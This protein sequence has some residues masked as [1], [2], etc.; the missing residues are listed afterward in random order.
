[1]YAVH[2]RDRDRID[3][4][5]IFAAAAFLTGI[6]LIAA[7]ARVGA[8]DRLVEALGPLI[9]LFGLIVVGVLTRTA[10]L[11]DFFAAGRAIPA[12]YGGLAFAGMAAG[13]A[14]VLDPGLTGHPPLPWPALALGVAGAALIVG[15]LLRRGCAGALSDAL[16][17]RYPGLPARLAFA[18]ALWGIGV[19]TA[20]AAFD[21]AV[22]I[23][24]AHVGQSRRP[25][26][27]I[28][29]LSVAM[30]IVPGGLKGLLWSDAAS[31]GGALAIA[32][33]GGGLAWSGAGA[34][35]PTFPQM[36]NDWLAL[37]RLDDSPAT[38]LTEIASALGVAT[39]FVFSPP[40]I[41]APPSRGL[42]AG[43]FG[44]V[45][46]VAGL[47]LAVAGMMAFSPDASTVRSPVVS[48]L[49]GAAT[50][51]PALALARAGV[52]GAARAAGIDLFTAYSRLTTLAS[53]RLARIRLMMILV[54]ALSAVA[55]DMRLLEPQ[56]A[57]L[58][59]LSLNVALIAPSLI[60]G[61]IPRGRSLAGFAALLT[62][63]AGFAWRNFEMTPSWEPR[64]MLIDALISGA[65][66]LLVGAVIGVFASGARKYGARADPFVDMPF[67]AAE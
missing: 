16:A 46:C 35:V 12:T 10:R 33:I 21:T 61:L 20:T 45:F 42:R 3:G 27:V 24:V 25:A 23:L 36:A 56:R 2:N 9:A 32:A 37:S 51:L 5:A 54:I 66:A 30:T 52:H 4:L 26:E 43:F 39:F 67:E 22:D 34:P 8:P 44:L 17:T 53:Q 11:G 18:L 62:G 41:G 65:A 1:M 29:A 64:K 38:L 59:A 31:A 49:I 14:V 48:A 60:L 57:I 40:A 47:A 15:P 28:V 13:M 19:L 55:S 7:L 6:G 50:W 58:L 63:A